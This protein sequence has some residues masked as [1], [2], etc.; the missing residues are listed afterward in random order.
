MS[1]KS[2]LPRQSQ[3]MSAATTSP[4][5]T[6][7]RAHP[8]TWRALTRCRS[9][10]F[11]VLQQ[12]ADQSQPRLGN[13]YFVR[14]GND[15]LD[16][17]PFLHPPGESPCS[18][19]IS[20]SHTRTSP[21]PRATSTKRSRI[22]VFLGNRRSIHLSHEGPSASTAPDCITPTLRLGGPRPRVAGRARGDYDTRFVL[23]RND[24]QCEVACGCSAD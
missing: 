23:A 6:S 4:C 18:L 20:F 7:G 19:I 14:G 5:L 15:E 13:Q 17:A 1:V 10:E 8:S 2:D 3:P 21:I 24:A 22:Q 9:L 16:E 11:R 12:R